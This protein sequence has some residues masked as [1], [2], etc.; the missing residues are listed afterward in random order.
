MDCVHVFKSD[1]II[2]LSPL[3][4]QIHLNHP[5]KCHSMILCFSR[6]NH[7]SVLLYYIMIKLDHLTQTTMNQVCEIICWRKNTKDL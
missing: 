7:G 4:F 3:I 6:S 2:Q 1:W 5:M